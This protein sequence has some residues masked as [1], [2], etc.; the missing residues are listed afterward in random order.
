MTPRL[1][2]NPDYT[3]GSD[4]LDDQHRQILAQCNA[5]ADCMDETSEAGRAEFDRRFQA[6]MALAQEHFATEEALLTGSGYPALEE[7]QNERDEFGYLADNI[8]KTEHFERS[9]LQRF[10][11]LW[12]V[13]HIVGSGT[14]HRPFL[15][16]GA[17]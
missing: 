6:L 10:L 15:Q 4:S 9:E 3:V 13:G 11:A 5:L 16:Q 1:Q 7:H 2:W 12:W 17:R 14:K 8:V